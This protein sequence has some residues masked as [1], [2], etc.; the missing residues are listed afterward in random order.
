MTFIV[1]ICLHGWGQAEFSGHSEKD[2]D[3][4]YYETVE[5]IQPR[6]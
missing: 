6:S 1:D 5:Y 4:N 3:D 2:Y